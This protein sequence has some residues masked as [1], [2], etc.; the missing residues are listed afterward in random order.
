M[1]ADGD[2][3]Q[4]EP[5]SD[6]VVRGAGTDHRID[7]QTSGVSA[8]EARVRHGFGLQDEYNTTIA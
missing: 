2:V 3:L 1:R 7:L 6:L 4:I 8:N 5:A